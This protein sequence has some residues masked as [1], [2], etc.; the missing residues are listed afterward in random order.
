MINNE[1]VNFFY[2]VDLSL[3]KIIIDPLKD[4]NPKWFKKSSPFLNVKN[5]TFLLIIE[6]WL[7]FIQIGENIS[8]SLFLDTHARVHTRTHT[9]THTISKI[10]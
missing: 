8:S 6:K 9:H 10:V 7:F 2:Y 3:M 1:I 5:T 4:Q